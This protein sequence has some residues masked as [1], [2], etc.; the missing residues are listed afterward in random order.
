ML[1]NL[2]ERLNKQ[3]EDVVATNQEN[4]ELR[5]RLA[6]VSEVL[7]L[8]EEIRSKYEAE[9]TRLGKEAVAQVCNCMDDYE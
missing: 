2:S 8:S 5:A 3:S 7:T 4:A 6:K 9:C 1:E